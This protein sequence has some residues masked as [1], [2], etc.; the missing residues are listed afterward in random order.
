MLLV[1]ILC[2][3]LTALSS[4]W[5]G[6]TH[7]HK[8][9]LLAL[10]LGQWAFL[11]PVLI[12]TNMVWPYTVG[13]DDVG[14]HEISASFRSLA[15]ALNPD[16]YVGVLEQPGYP[17]LLSPAALLSGGNLLALKLVNLSSLIVTTMVWSRIGFDL[18]DERF[19][20]LVGLF[21]AALSPL[22]FYSFFLLKDLP[23]VFLQS[24]AV[25]GAVFLIQGRARVGLMLGVAA[26]LLIIPLRSNLAA[27]NVGLLA[28][29]AALS[30][31]AT[32]KR[33][34]RRQREQRMFIAAASLLGTVG[35]IYLILDPDTAYAL[36]LRVDSRLLSRENL[37]YAAQLQFEGSEMQ[38]ALF[39]VL[40][41][42]SETAGLRA[43]FSGGAITPDTLRGL[44]ALPWILFYL[45][46]VLL[47]VWVLV[48]SKGLAGLA[49]SP[50]VIVMT[51]CL[52][53]LG[54]SWIVGDTT[55]WRIADLPALATI[56]ALGFTSV[57]GSMGKLIV[58]AWP[59][60]IL[61]ASFVFYVILA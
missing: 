45:P 29:G 33:F 23:I 25:L 57:K 60:L 12:F 10:A 20:R 52:G 39:P 18:E 36:G 54:I 47:G 6:R 48:S 41:L 49:G 16:S 43:L 55:R 14:Y 9:F 56:A 3:V 37:E 46:F 13:G 34:V 32:G 35:L 30:S 15:D 1:L 8:R 26:T 51:F 44:L 59:T 7:R 17:I 53:Y 2:V 21:V 40:Y 11:L 27:V 38:R 50:W 22:W 42:V 58:T 24:L 4:F 61:M 28:A 5:V 19:A 31:F